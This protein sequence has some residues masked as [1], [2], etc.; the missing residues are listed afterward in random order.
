M[1]GLNHLNLVV[2]DVDASAGFYE[3]V[4][5]M[6]PQHREGGFVFLACGETDL[7]L[8]QGRPNVHRRF[9][10]GFRL[11]TKD[12][13]DAWLREVRRHG[14]PV[15]HG[16]QDYGE[17]YTFTVRDPDG[18]GVEIYYE[19]GPRGRVGAVGETEE[20]ASSKRAPGQ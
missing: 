11:D 16:P 7:A 18:Y 13:V 10:F 2:Q 4:F 9:H 3:S 20:D 6:E 5:G 12:E 19:A 17:Y 14:A 8:V 15:T 1:R